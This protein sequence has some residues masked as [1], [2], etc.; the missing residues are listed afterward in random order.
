MVLKKAIISAVLVISILLSFSMGFVPA[1]AVTQDLVGRVIFLDPGHGIGAAGGGSANGYV[2]HV[3]MLSLARQ[4]APLLAARGATVYT[5]RSDE[6][7]VLLPARAAIINMIALQTVRETYT[8]VNNINEIDRLIGVMQGIINNPDS[9]GQRLMNTPFHASRTIHHDL[10]RTFEYLNNPLIRNNF[11]MISLH[12]NA[13]ASGGSTGVRGGE[14]YYINPSEFFNTATYYTGYPYVEQSRRFA[15]ILLDHIAGVRYG[16][17]NIP[18]RSNG[19]RAE[20]YFINREVGIPSVLAENGYHTNATERALLLNSTYMGMLASAYVDAV[21]Q[22]FAALPLATNTKPVVMDAI[23]VEQFVR[24]LY[25]TALGRQPDPSGFQN[26]Q[27]H[28]MTG[29]M[30]GATVA[31][32]FIF[33]AEYKSRNVTNEQFVDTLYRTLLDREPDSSGRANWIGHLNAWMPR[34][35]VFTLF[36]N[37]PEYTN[38]CRSYGIPH[39]NFPQPA[40]QTFYVPPREIVEAFVTRLYKEALGREPDLSGLDNWTGHLMSGRMTGSAVAMSF[41]NSLEMSNKNLDDEDFVEMLYMSMLG[42]ASDPSGKANW[43]GH[44]KTNGMSRHTVSAHFANSPEF[45][46]ICSKYMIRH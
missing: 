20:N 22:Y 8:D 27:N 42:R 15:D 44:M 34:E 1:Q 19:L 2:E 10:R 31:F 30:S 13:P 40:S 33:S 12:S 25:V 41:T 9:E 38:L 37:S 5:T 28:L 45:A 32:S 7:D 35:T 6:Y 17:N 39:S 11:L 4:I 29:N 14:V 23:L 24:R 46:G 16:G 43:L 18:R 26:W 36:A 21:V 3:H